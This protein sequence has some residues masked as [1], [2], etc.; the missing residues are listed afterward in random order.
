MPKRQCSHSTK[1]RTKGKRER[2]LSNNDDERDEDAPPHVSIT[3][4]NAS[5]TDALAGELCLT[6]TASSSSEQRKEEERKPLLVILPGSSGHL[7]KAMRSVFLASLSQHFEVRV[8]DGKWRGWNPVGEK[9]VQSVLDVSPSGAHEYDWYILGNSF[10]N[11]VLCAMCTEGL[12]PTP[13]RGLVMCGYPMYGPKG[14]DERVKLL[15]SLDLP[16]GTKLLCIS[17][18]KDE[19][20]LRGG[21]DAQTVYDSVL[22]GMTP[23]RENHHQQQVE[24]RILASGKH[25]VIDHSNEKVVEEA[26]AT[27]LNWILTF[28]L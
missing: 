20:L 7:G 25:G 27:V 11:R 1:R 22:G 16:V 5:T 19:F 21:S 17:G 14:T 4:P 24:V 3:N 23:A 10:G 2:K 28:F 13:P 6:A 18:A 9:N 26:S 8:R 12:F 15:Q